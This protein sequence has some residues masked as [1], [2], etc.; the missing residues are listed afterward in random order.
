MIRQA[1]LEIYQGDDYAGFVTVLNADGTPADLSP[2]TAAAQIRRKYADSEP[3]VAAEFSTEIQAPNIIIL[4]LT[5]DETT[6][7]WGTYFWDLQLTETA[8]GAVNTILAGKVPVYP[9]VT[10]AVGRRKEVAA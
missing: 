6:P 8:T 4:G 7:L 10:R 1:K 2:F 5:H 9:E 3:V